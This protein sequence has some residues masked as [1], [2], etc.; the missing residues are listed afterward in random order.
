MDFDHAWMVPRQFLHRFGKGVAQAGDDLEQTKVCV[1]E[2]APDQPA[3]LVALEHLLEIAKELRRALLEKFRRPAPGFL[4]LVLIVEP[5]ADRMMRVVRFHHEIRQRELQLM[6]P[7]A[8]F[9]A[10]R[11]KAVALAEKEKDVRG[12]P[13]QELAGFQEGRGKRRM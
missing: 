5:D 3:G 13:D 12:L 9:F 2:G 11:R 7:Q 6:R 4:L 8:A 1:S 10:L